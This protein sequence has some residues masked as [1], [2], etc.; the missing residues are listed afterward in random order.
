MKQQSKL[1]LCWL[2]VR[3][4]YRFY[5]PGQLIPVAFVSTFSTKIVRIC[6]RARPS[7]DN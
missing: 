4:N 3:A 7:G 1:Y 6:D 5:T 2:T